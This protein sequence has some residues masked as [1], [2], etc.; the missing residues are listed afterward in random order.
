MVS[1]ENAHAYQE[2]DETLRRSKV[3]QKNVYINGVARK[4]SRISIKGRNAT[5][6]QGDAEKRLYK[7]CHQKMLTNI[8]KETKRSDAAR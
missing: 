7:W 6:Q 4:C 3:T 1:P 8:D 5:T 2:R